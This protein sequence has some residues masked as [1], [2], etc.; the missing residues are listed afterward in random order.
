MLN[1]Y[2]KN[3]VT[4]RQL[5]LILYVFLLLFSLPTSY[6]FGTVTAEYTVE[7]SIRFEVSPSPFNHPTILAAKLGTFKITSTTGKIY[8]PSFVN[9]SSSRGHISVTGMMKSDANGQYKLGSN[10]FQIISVAYPL[11]R[12]GAPVLNVFYDAYEPIISDGPDII[13]QDPFEVELFLVNT[14]STNPNNASEY[15]QA[16]FFKLDSPFFLPVDFSPYCTVGVADSASTNVG[17]YASTGTVIE[18]TG[19]FVGPNPNQAGPTDTIVL[20]PTAY[21]DPN[22]PNAPPSSGIYYGDNPDPEPDPPDYQFTIINETTI[23]LSQAY[24]SSAKVADA[25]MTIIDGIQGET[26]EAYISFASN[27]VDSEGFN[28]RLTDNQNLYKIPYNLIFNNESVVPVVLGVTPTSNQII[29]WEGIH[30]QNATVLPIY[31]TGID[32]STAEQAPAGTYSDTITVTI[33]PVD[34]L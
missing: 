25:Q 22:N 10:S 8:S 6:V 4:K 32:Q 5:K 26:Y 12:T 13:E 18:S 17:T 14:N 7:S 33:I 23:N 9:I 27:S 3:R 15:R 30:Y 16:S 21:S 24:E 31:V 2:K 28:L 20:A 34:T 19:S 11:G 29:P 1:R